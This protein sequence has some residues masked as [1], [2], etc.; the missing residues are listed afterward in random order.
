MK[1]AF[2]FSILTQL[3]LIVLLTA[4]D[5]DKNMPP[6]NL[7][8]F[9]D[10]MVGQYLESDTTLSLFY[11]LTEKTKVKG[12]LNSY[13]AYSLF[14]PTN[15]ALRTYLKE[16]GKTSF[17]QFSSDTLKLLVYDHLI[18]GEVVNYTK[19]NIGRLFQMTMSDRYL[20][21]SFDA[22]NGDIFVNKDSRIVQKDIILY[23]GII[24]KIDKVLEPVRAG[25]VEVVAKDTLFT[26]FYE[27]LLTT[28]LA[29]SLLKT[30]DESYVMTSAY[31]KELEDAVATT[32]S[33]ERVAPWSRK[34]GYTLLME[35]DET[36]KKNGI[37]DIESLKKYAAEVYDEL[38]PDDAHIKDITNRR[39]SLN[40][41]VAYHIIEK[42]LSYT[43]FIKD[44]DTGHMLKTIDMYE[45]IEPMCPN[46]LIEVMIKRSSGEFNIFNFL[47]DSQKSIRIV[48][49]NFDNDSENG[50]YH[51]ISDMLVFSKDVEAMI[52]GKRLRFDFASMFN[53]LTNNNMRGRP[54]D[55][56]TTLYRNALPMG[57]LSRLE[58][59]EQSVV[60]YSAPHDK[61]MN[62]MGDEFFI[63]V[64]PGKLYN[65]EVTTPPV[66]VGT[67]EVRFGY[68]S[69]GRRGVAQFYV[70]GIPSGVP[71]NLN[72]TGSHVGIGYVRP[73]DNPDDILGFENDKMMRN[74]GYMKGPASFKSI[75]EA[76]YSGASARHNGGNLRKILGTYHF[77]EMKSR[78]I[79]IKGLS[80][81]QFQIDFIEFVPTSVIEWEDVN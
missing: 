71:V 57:Y 18:N 72:N 2:K 69:N 24:H 4:C 42:E 51:E 26:I 8:T 77:S 61:L 49:G 27:A 81:G 59:T 35:S 60:C 17:D 66:P 34:Y 48:Q 53:E 12:L 73:G 54:S 7:F 44:Y 64:K 31:A 56:K 41:F 47:P 45:Y 9:Q 16:K 5:P 63:S 1:N 78:K 11:Q 22:S 37:S 15:E 70:D 19:F 62:F 50:V 21:I 79:L 52:S 33:S 75:N 74:R 80:S 46:T 32:V 20:T 40:R 6:E 29:D 28:G 36:M 76:W 23:N 3:L 55:D 39:N 10:Q 38:Y 67:Y 25:L 30:V 58:M 13:G 68:Q 65:I 43:K 14:L